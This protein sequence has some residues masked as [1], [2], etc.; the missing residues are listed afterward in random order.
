MFNALAQFGVGGGERLFAD[1]AIVAAGAAGQ[2]AEV[3][4]RGVL[5][6]GARW[7]E[8][9]EGEQGCAVVV[10]GLLD[11]VEAGAAGDVVLAV[12]EEDDDPSAWQIGI[13]AAAEFEGAQQAKIELGLAVLGLQ[14]GEM[15]V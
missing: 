1:F 4:E 6:R 2:Q 9:A 5:S 7:I 14:M 3:F 13:L 15:G 12:G 10:Q 8:Q 11:F